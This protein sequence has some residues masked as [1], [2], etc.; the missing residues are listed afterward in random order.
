MAGTGGLREQRYGRTSTRASCRR[1]RLE[2]WG[3]LHLDH[4]DFHPRVLALGLRELLTARGSG[5]S[6]GFS[7]EFRDLPAE[8]FLIADAQSR[9][10][11]KN[12]S[13][14]D[15]QGA[16]STALLCFCALATLR[17]GDNGKHPKDRS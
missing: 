9:Q 3:R 14:L 4:F 6:F 11:A 8:M 5:C 1:G 10:D 2:V 12:Q 15:G 16:F 7:Y 17:L 13:Q